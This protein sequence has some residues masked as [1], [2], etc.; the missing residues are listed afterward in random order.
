MVSK[1]V[2]SP[3]VA[4]IRDFRV[5]IEHGVNHNPDSGDLRK[6]LHTNHYELDKQYK[7]Y[8]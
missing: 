1:K 5:V 3:L 4:E 8:Q 6:K 7:K 2:S